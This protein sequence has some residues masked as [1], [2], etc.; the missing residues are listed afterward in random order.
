MD[1]QEN[2]DARSAG[3]STDSLDEFE[4]ALAEVQGENYVLCL[5]IS[6]I[7]PRSIE[8]VRNIKKICDDYLSGHYELDVVD[9]YQQPERASEGQVVAAPM[10]VKSSPLPY[11]RII[12]TLPVTPETLRRM[13]VRIDT[14]P[15]KDK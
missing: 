14:P 13:D 6:G 7:T 2:P 5:Y 11:R 10:L 3:A 9:I 1:K 8:A 4:K 12:G 15:E